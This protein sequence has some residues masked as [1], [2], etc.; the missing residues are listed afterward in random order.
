MMRWIADRDG[1]CVT[2][3]SMTSDGDSQTPVDG[4]RAPGDG[5]DV[6]LIDAMLRLTPE[7]RLDQHARMV[8]TIEELR[9]GWAE[10]RSTSDGQ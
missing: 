5:V 7:Q 10:C 3:K 8:Q 1:R 2:V 4:K 9:V 6:S